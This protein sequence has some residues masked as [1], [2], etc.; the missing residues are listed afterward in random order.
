VFK[1]KG[2]LGVFLDMDNG[3]LEFAIDG[4]YFG[5]AFKDKIL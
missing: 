1:K 4:E 3:T 2:I 5:V